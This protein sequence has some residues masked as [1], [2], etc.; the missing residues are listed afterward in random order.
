MKQYI[1]ILIALMLLL[2]MLPAQPAAGAYCG[3]MVTNN[4]DSGLGSL[5]EALTGG[6]DFIGFNPDLSSATIILQT[7]LTIDHNVT[8]D[9]TGLASKVTISGN[10]LY[11]LIQEAKTKNVTIA[12]LMHKLPNAQS[13]IIVTPGPGVVEQAPRSGRKK[14]A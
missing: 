8:I 2:A 14:N 5:R 4:L 6:C 12:S 3:V 13:K 9:A 7:P 11:E 10:D 1:N